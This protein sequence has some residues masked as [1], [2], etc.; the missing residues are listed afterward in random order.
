MTIK[1]ELKDSYEKTHSA[2]L[3]LI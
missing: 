2:I 1:F 3:F